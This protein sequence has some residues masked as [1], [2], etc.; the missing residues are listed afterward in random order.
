MSKSINF[1]STKQAKRLF[2]V[3]SRTT[4]F[5]SNTKSKKKVV[6]DLR[7]LAN[8][9]C[10]FGQIAINYARIFSS[11]H[12][13]HLEFAYLLPHG[14]QWPYGDEAEWHYDKSEFQDVDLWHSV[15]QFQIKK[16]PGQA[17]TR[18]L[19]I[20]DLNFLREKG[21]L[22]QMKNKLRINL[23]I[24]RSAAVTCISHF[25]ADEVRRHFSLSG[26]PLHVIYNGVQ[27][28]ADHPQSRPQFATGRPFFFT[29]GQIRAKKNFHLL[30][31]VMKSFPDHDLY[32]CG[33]DH[34]R[35]ADHIRRRIE[36]EGITNVRLTGPISAE[37]KV[38]LYAQC[39]AFLFPSGGEGFGL[40]VIEAFQFGKAVYISSL[41]CLP[42]IAGGHAIVWDDLTTE[43]MVSTIKDTLPHFYDDAS[44]IDAI[45]QYA[46]SFSYE[47]HVS[48]Y[49]RL[50]K[51]ILGM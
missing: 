19:T 25:V 33:D 42:E 24:R 1:A 50:Y 28:I 6:L 23:A 10:G 46:A 34:F 18:L 48:A 47:A 15:N 39:E 4:I 31:D 16:A 5:M 44:R 20:H 45:R 12:D 13:D 14:Y 35:H 51:Q 27:P 8:P 22:S 41:T 17:Q 9:L 36:D 49:V 2:A 43:T 29:I 3:F 40:P 38:W 32:I 30:L 11:L 26:R 37:E 7:D 21:W